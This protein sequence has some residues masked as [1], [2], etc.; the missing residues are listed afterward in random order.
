MNKFSIIE[1][2][3]RS[4]LRRMN[5][6]AA[7]QKQTPTEYCLQ[8]VRKSDY[9]N[10]L[11]TLLLPHSIKSAAFA[12]RAFN[13]EVA[14]VE[15]Q[16]SD[17][18]IGAMRLQFWTDALNET[19][20]NN[21]PKSPVAMELHRILQRYKLSKRYFKRL[22]EARLNKLSGSI[23]VDLESLERYCDYTTSSIYYLLLEAQGTT[24]VKADHAASH[25]GKSHGLV[26]LIRSVPYNARKRAMV[27]PQDVLL[28]NGV[29]SESIF[30]GRSSAGFKD[31]VLEVASCAKR[32]LKV[33]TSLKKTA[34]KD[35]NVLFLP[36]ICIENYLE[37]LRKVDFDVFHPRLQRRNGFLPLQLLWRKMW[38]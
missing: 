7:R 3:I 21:P 12:I 16:V 14:Q 10:Y 15:D 36:G 26:T 17:S 29:S 35:L 23:F 1:R 5:T 2:N 8:L 9:E 20:N 38:S 34:E 33:A 37:E 32:H 11:C 19:Y 22:I 30:Q 28:K 27:L 6:N 13:V 24:N 18:R 4:Q 25:F 31:A